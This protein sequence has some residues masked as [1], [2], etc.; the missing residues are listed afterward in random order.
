MWCQI[1][2]KRFLLVSDCPRK[3]SPITRG[4]LDGKTVMVVGI[5]AWTDHSDF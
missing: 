3:N 5:Q 1:D 4:R 2:T